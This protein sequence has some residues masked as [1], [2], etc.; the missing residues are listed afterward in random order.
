ELPS[1]GGEPGESPEETA[2]RELLEETG[3]AA[4]KLELVGSLFVDTGRMETIQ[5]LYFARDAPIVQA[6]DPGAGE[7]LETLFVTPAELRARDLLLVGAHQP[8]LADD[9]LA[10]DVEALDAVRA[11]EDEARHRVG[12]AREREPVRAPDGEVGLL[13]GLDRA[14][15]VAAQDRGSAAGA[16][17]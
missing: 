16:E 9:L 12:G 1:G 5:R 11:G 4:P 13:A 8:A 10:A 17:P 2:R 14:D 3:C 15:V 7:E 6:P